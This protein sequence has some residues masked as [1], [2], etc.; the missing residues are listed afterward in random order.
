MLKV[1][2]ADEVS[3]LRQRL[4][5][6][7]V[8]FSNDALSGTDPKHS[9][10][11]DGLLPKTLVIPRERLNFRRIKINGGVT[12]IH[13]AERLRLSQEL[14]KPD[15]KTRLVLDGAN[16]GF[17]SLWAWSA[18]EVSPFDEQILPVR[19]VPEP[20]L[21]PGIRSGRRLVECIE[22]FEGQV[23]DGGALSQSRWWPDLPTLSEWQMF[24]R[25]AGV[26]TAD[27]YAPIPERLEVAA[28]FNANEI[29]DQSLR[30]FQTPKLFLAATLVA[31][32]VLIGFSVTSYVGHGAAATILRD[33]LMADETSFL[34]AKTARESAL[35]LQRQVNEVLT[36]LPKIRTV[37]MT[38]S[39][40]ES[41]D[42]EKAV[43]SRVEI[44]NGEFA[45]FLK[46]ASDIDRVVM[47]K[48]LEEVDGVSG[49]YAEPTLRVGE[50]V[51]RG[52]APNLSGT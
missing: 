18:D 3:K 24:M 30:A 9:V 4:K 17:A 21:Y 41:V 38:T 50:L 20:L 16:E 34:A 39:L 2:N 45:I 43:I 33:R 27:N 48:R 49:V 36:S 32:F 52:Q 10:L 35:R 28:P 42:P 44:S 14:D 12:Q 11:R 22:G 46:N 15:L 8:F 1:F 19:V 5:T 23:W 37:D 51:F 6:K 13:R 7:L 26:A 31:C 40:Y 25:S 29:N 47:I